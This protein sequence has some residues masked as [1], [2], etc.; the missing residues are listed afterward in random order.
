MDEDNIFKRINSKALKLY[1]LEKELSIDSNNA[2]NI[3]LNY[4]GNKFGFD[5]SKFSD[6]CIDFNKAV[7]RNIENSI[8]SVK[9]PLGYVGDIKVNGIYA[10]SLYPILMATTEGKLVAGVSRGINIVDLNGGVSTKVLSDGMTRD[11][12]VDAYNIDNAFIVK[13]FIESNEGNNFLVKAFSENT[14]HGKMNSVKV[15]QIGKLLHIRFN[16][17]TGSA[18][19][20][21]M[22]TIASKHA[23]DS[24]IDRFK[25]DSI[26]LKII[27]ESGNMCSDKK[28]SYINFLEGRGV[29][30]TAE[31]IISEKT[32]NKFG[33][34]S[35][36]IERLN[37]LKNLEGSAMAGSNGFNGHVANILAAM[38]IA[39]GQD[40]AQ[41]VEGSQA[42]VEAESTEKGLYISILM[43]SI[44]V[45]TYGGGTSLESQKEALKMIGL[46]GSND[47]KG[48]TRL[49][50]AEVICSVALAGELNLLMVEAANQLSSSHGSLN[51]K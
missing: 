38:Y 43:P 49:A 46:Y 36:S 51:R 35:R 45:G 39:Y 21:N 28:P 47:Y 26:E 42:I 14:S 30:I 7:N 11:I 19:G 29:S 22:I 23:I 32:L 44:E 15:F 1:D 3:R 16:A 25:L 33:I 31:A 12:L 8:G 27:S 40:V 50:F 34:S 4:L 5:T 24:L 10:K 17:F 9:I 20:M 37:R 2:T 18:M 41:I 6:N 48:I 13:N